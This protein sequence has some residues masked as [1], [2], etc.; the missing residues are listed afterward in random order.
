M[1]RISLSLSRNGYNVE[2]VGRI[3]QDSKPLRLASYKQKR[4]S[5]IFQKGKLF[6]AEYNLRLFFYLFSRQADI[7]SAVD[8]DTLVPSFLVSR[9]KGKACVYD[10]HEYFTEV[11]EVINRPLVRKIW[12]LIESWIIPRL[13]HCYTVSESIAG[14][15]TKKYGTPFI[16]IRNMPLLNEEEQLSARENREKYILYQGALNKGRGLETLIKAMQHIDCKLHL[17]GEGDLSTAL[18]EKVKRLNLSDKVIFLGY[19][20]PEK[21]KLITQHAYIGINVSEN[22]GLSYY[23]SLNNKYFDYIHA[24]LPSVIN[25]FPEYRKLCEEYE[26]G[27]L[28]DLNLENLIGAIDMLLKDEALYTR[29]KNNCREAARVYNWQN[30]ESKL[31]NVYSGIV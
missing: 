27:L 1:H 9:L 6:Y 17:A 5:C 7:Y 31:L 12:L 8:L 18:R 24:G 16:T 2:L 3:K 13:N 15:F 11:P 21:L 4:L 29:L 10:A 19:T 26:V 30:E 22:I 23:Y 25:D 20:E 14:I 28:I